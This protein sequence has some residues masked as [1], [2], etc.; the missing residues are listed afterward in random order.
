MPLRPSFCTIRAFTNLNRFSIEPLRISEKLPR[1][2]STEQPQLDKESVKTEKKKREYT[3][4]VYSSEKSEVF[5][6]SKV[7]IP[8]EVCL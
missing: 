3:K 4:S 7:S 6:P 5:I 2:F 1:T 8:Q